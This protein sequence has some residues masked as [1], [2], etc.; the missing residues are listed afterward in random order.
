MLKNKYAEM[1]AK[2]ILVKRSMVLLNKLT[3]IYYYKSQNHH[4]GHQAQVSSIK[5]KEML[6]SS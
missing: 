6:T 3:K 2:E 5:T 1:S 4:I